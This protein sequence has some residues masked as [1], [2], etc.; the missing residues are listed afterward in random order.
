MANVQEILIGARIAEKAVEKVATNVAPGLG[1]RFAAAL[2][3]IFGSAGKG[4]KGSESTNIFQK[5]HLQKTD[6]A[7]VSKDSPELFDYSKLNLDEF[8]PFEKRQAMAMRA[9]TFSYERASQFKHDMQAAIGGEDQALTRTFDRMIEKQVAN[10][11]DEMHYTDSMMSTREGLAF[12]DAV[13]KTHERL[14]PVIENLADELHIPRP[15]FQISNHE[16]GSASFTPSS[17]QLSMSASSLAKD[18]AEAPN[19]AYHEITHAEQFNLVIRRAADKLGIGQAADE[20]QLT[21][22][23]EAVKKDAGTFISDNS[24]L[25]ES[26]RLRNGA[27]LM[28]EEMRRADE[29]ATSFKSLDKTDIFG[30]ERRQA[31]EMIKVMKASGDEPFDQLMRNHG[32]VQQLS[33]KGYWF[34]RQGVPAEAKKIAADWQAA[35]SREVFTAEQ[36]RTAIDQIRRILVQRID[37]INADEMTRFVN[38]RTSL[39][40]VEAYEAGDQIGTTQVLKMIAQKGANHIPTVPTIPTYRGLQAARQAA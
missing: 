27:R 29:L 19:M 4:A 6:S 11:W 5:A 25:M 32:L 38:Y 24:Y 21:A 1:E 36:E 9:P 7:A 39:H 33:G 10:G 20:T 15:K 2:P 16:R 18:F 13:W 3:E 17:N 28:P 23:R 34:N 8:L 22:L 14:K 30:N 40:E 26:L 35:G 31:Y 12:Q 37:E